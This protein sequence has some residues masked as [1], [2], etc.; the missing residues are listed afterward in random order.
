MPNLWLQCTDC[1][2]IWDQIKKRSFGIFPTPDGGVRVDECPDC[3]SWENIISKIKSEDLDLLTAHE[4]EPMSYP[5]TDEQAQQIEEDLIRREE[6][7]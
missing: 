4:A 2:R 6:Q 3:G 5:L 1:G 7:E